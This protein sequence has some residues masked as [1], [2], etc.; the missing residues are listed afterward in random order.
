MSRAERYC[1]LPFLSA[2]MESF[3]TAVNTEEIYEGNTE[4]DRC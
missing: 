1:D 4:E 2:L 3:F